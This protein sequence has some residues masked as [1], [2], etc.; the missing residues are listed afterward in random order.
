MAQGRGRPCQG[1]SAGGFGGNV[2]RSRRPRC[3]AS[4]HVERSRVNTPPADLDESELIRLLAHGWGVDAGV[5]S[6]LPKGFGSHHWLADIDGGTRDFLTV[7][8][9]GRKPWVGPGRE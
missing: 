5:L 1:R 8:D 4:A 9:L 2:R 6:Y 3:L 7:D